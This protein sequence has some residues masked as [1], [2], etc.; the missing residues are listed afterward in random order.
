MAE[1]IGAL[2]PTQIPSLSDAADIQEA[3]RLYHYGAPSGTNIGEYDTSGTNPSNLP[4]NS[5]AAYINTLNTKVAA[6]EAAPGVLATQWNAKGALVTATANSVVA[7]LPVG[8]N[9]TVLTA[10]SGTV[11]GLEW[12]APSVTPNNTQTFTNKSIDLFSNIL[13]GTLA[14]FNLALTDADFASIA[15]AETLTNK[16][17]TSPAINNPSVTGLYL[18][19]SNITFEGATVD[20][21][22]TILT[23]ANPTADRTITLPNATGNV[24]TTGNLSE[25]TSTGTLGSLTV[26]GNVVYH[27]D[28]EYTSGGVVAPATWD[29]KFVQVNS[30]TAVNISLPDSSVSIPKGAQFI[31]FQE[32]VGQVNIAS[33]N[34]STSQIF[35]SPGTKL[36]SRYSSCT[37]I[38]LSDA[39]A[40]VQQWAVIGDLVA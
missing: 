38:K 7:T 40:A 16:T 18:S 22:E 3:F 39:A 26:T 24:I 5:I 29:G 9:G 35:A 2:I 28:F 31:V 30:P 13:T 20:D 8:S 21:F 27:L 4:P 15:G 17:L 12:V 36:R 32:G 23:A 19:D 11:T 34:P 33:A 14:Q 6:L 25:I 1:Q 37:I 10:N